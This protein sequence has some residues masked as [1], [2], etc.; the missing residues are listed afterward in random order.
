VHSPFGGGTTVRVEL[1]LTA[2]SE[3]DP[4][5]AVAGRP[6]DIA[7]D[8]STDIDRPPRDD[9]WDCGTDV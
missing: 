8:I 3:P 2:A 9:A 1:P 7:S 4:A 5:M 6:S